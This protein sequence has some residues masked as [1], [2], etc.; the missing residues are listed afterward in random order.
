MRYVKKDH[1]SPPPELEAYVE[2]Y[3]KRVLTGNSKLKN[4]FNEMIRPHLNKLYYGKCAYCESFSEPASTIEVDHYRP[5]SKYRW[6]AFEWSNLL[7]ACKKCN[8]KKSNRFPLQDEKLKFNSSN[9]DNY[10]VDSKTLMDKEKPL[11]LNPELDNPTDHL[12]YTPPYGEIASKSDSLKGEKTI[13]ICGLNRDGLQEAYKRQIDRIV[14]TIADIT[15]IIID[16]KESNPSLYEKNKKYRFSL[17]LLYLKP[18][19]ELERLQDPKNTGAYTQ[20]GYQMYEEFDD[21]VIDRL[22]NY[23]DTK[24]IVRKVFILFRDGKLKR[25]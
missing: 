25:I 4:K 21:F 12:V 6:L 24:A 8:S 16:L 19:Q 10:K 5:T 18:F 23:K 22:P 17:Y 14:D 7:P 9:G 13:E 11:L 20:L 15:V 2:K 3:K 1:N